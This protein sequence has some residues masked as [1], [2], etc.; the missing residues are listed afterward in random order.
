MFFNIIHERDVLDGLVELRVSVMN[1]MEQG[2]E[3]GIFYVKNVETKDI[4][5]INKYVDSAFGS[6]SSYRVLLSSGEYLA[7]EFT[8]DKSDN[9]YVVRKVLYGEDI[10]SDNQ[11]ATEIYNVYADFYNSYIQEPMSDFDKEVAVHD[12]LVKRCQ[13]GYPENTDDAYD[14]YGIMV[15]GKAV[16]DGYAEAF[17]LMVTCLGIDCDI[18][19]GTADGESHAWNQIKLDNQW[20]NVDLTWDDSLPDM[21]EYVKHTYMNVDDSALGVTHV[22]DGEFYN[23]CNSRTKS[24][25]QS[26]FAFYQD[27]DSFKTGILRQ[28]GRSSLVWEAAIDGYTSKDIDLTFLY[29]S[30]N[31]GR[32]RYLVED[33]GTYKVV[34]IYVN[35]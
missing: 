10:P 16:C 12:Y 20:Y 14:A 26:T 19:V 15:E 1:S 32:I 29:D 21:G 27:Y 24:Y 34:V 25:Y 13:Y 9:Y 28:A 23:E 4:N 2:K 5:D 6:V 11:R 7:I 18:V 3:T 33:M 35:T 30:T 22:W 31:V 17:F 8:F